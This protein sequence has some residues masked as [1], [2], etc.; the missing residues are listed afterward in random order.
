MLQQE[1]VN[2]QIG[3]C[4]RI[5]GNNIHSSS[6][7]MATTFIHLHFRYYLRDVNSMPM[8]KN[9]A[10]R[11][12][13]LLPISCDKAAPTAETQPAAAKLEG[14]DRTRLTSRPF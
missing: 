5:N 12:R 3:D 7:S 6:L 11:G 14:P 9:D 8:K 13:Q 10:D 1:F 2:R 4:A